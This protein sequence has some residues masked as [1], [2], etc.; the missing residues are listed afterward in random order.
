MELGGVVT[1]GCEKT[2]YHAQLEFKLKVRFLL[3]LF[4]RIALFLF[5]SVEI[6]MPSGRDSVVSLG[7]F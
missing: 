4:S 1:I 3:Q 6:L 2:G 7:I 5:D